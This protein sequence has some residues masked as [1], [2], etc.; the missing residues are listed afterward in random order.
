MDLGGC[1]ADLAVGCGYKYL[2]GGPGSPAF[3]FVAERLHDELRS[4]LF[5]WM[6]HAAAFDFVDDYRPAPGIA[7]F[8][9]GTPPILGVLALEVGVDL[10]LD[11]DLGV[12]E[13]KAA[14]L[15]DLFAGQVEVRCASH[16]FELLTSREAARR[17]THI[18]F[19][20]PEGYRIMQA[21]I[22]RG[23]I[24]DFRDPDVVRFGITPLYVGYEDV[25][26]AVEILHDVMQGGAWREEPARARGRVT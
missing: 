13:R 24:G 5:G 1:E 18:A 6:G 16:G 14:R 9:C 17:G 3:L 26:R 20:H 7:R 21:L 8:L 15:W 2:N 23:V 25:W 22:G 12:V 11:A 4:P 10:A 19:A